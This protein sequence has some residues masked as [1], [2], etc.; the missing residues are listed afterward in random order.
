M[1]LRRIAALVLVA[2]VAPGLVNAQPAASA[3]SASA[4]EAGRRYT[5]WLLEGRLDSLVPRMSPAFLAGIGGRAAVERLHA[6]LGAQL[7]QERGVV[8][9]SVFRGPG[10]TE[11]AR[12]SR[13][14]G[15]GEGTV[16]T[17]WTWTSRTDTI[18]GAIVSPTPAPAPTEHLDH[19]TRTTL[20]LPFDAPTGEGAAWY[21]GW[22]GRAPEQNYHVV[23]PDQR[24]AYDFL[25]VRPDGEGRFA[26]HRGSGT[27]NED[28]HCFG[29]P[30]LAPAAG[31]VTVALDSVA[32]NVPG[33]TNRAV[34]P[35][36]HVV[37][38]HGE[39]EF[40]LLAH[41]RRGSVRV[42]AG[43]TVGAGRQV[44]ECGNSGN[45]SEAHVHYHLQTGAAFGQGVGLPAPFVAYEADGRPVAR[46]E[47][48]R[49]QHIRPSAP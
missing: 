5:R 26:T 3:D 14:T 19:R 21:V 12:V 9:E 31:R 37:I 40:S 2:L 48:T 44:G 45:S 4:L 10:V 36:N 33:Q 23:A 49:G 11:Y 25:V 27:T 42:A 29:L 34:V 47:P 22:G 18:V 35:G 41:L 30:V 6:S 28:Y 20:R 7:G 15:N 43:D 38:D 17:R 13:F 8:R 39:G 24:F 1:S 46:G 32:D 16:T